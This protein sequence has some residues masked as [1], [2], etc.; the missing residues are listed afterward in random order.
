MSQT[1]LQ[2]MAKDLRNPL[3]PNPGS[4]RHPHSLRLSAP[5]RRLPSPPNHR[6]LAR[7]NVHLHPR[8]HGNQ[9]RRIRKGVPTIQIQCLSPTLQLRRGFRHRLRIL[10]VHGRGERIAAEPGGRDDHLRI[11][12]HH[13]EHG[14]DPHEKRGGGTRRRPSSMRRSAISWECSSVRR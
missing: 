5:R 9:N 13:G 12:S 1:T 14:P 4:M 2:K 10:P 11:T 7:R 8:R 6:H 3:L